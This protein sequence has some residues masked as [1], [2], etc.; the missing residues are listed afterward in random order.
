MVDYEIMKVLILVE[1]IQI[2][3]WNMG[4]TIPRK[5]T[6]GKQANSG[7][8]TVQNEKI[9]TVTPRNSS[10]SEMI[11]Q[12]PI[13]LKLNRIKIIRLGENFILIQELRFK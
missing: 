1:S 2:I 12:V 8:F 4:F 5:F 11:L 9:E 13:S 10:G 3:F 6:D 7:S